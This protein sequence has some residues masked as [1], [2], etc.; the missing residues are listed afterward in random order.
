[1][2]KVP[3]KDVR[4]FVAV[5]T[6]GS[7]FPEGTKLLATGEYRDPLP[8]ELF[9]ANNDEDSWARGDQLNVLIL[10][11]GIA[12]GERYIL[13]G[14]TAEGVA[15]GQKESTAT[16]ETTKTYHVSVQQE[17][18]TSFASRPDVQAT[19]PDEAAESYEGFGKRLI[20]REKG[21]KNL[22]WLYE[23]VDKPRFQKV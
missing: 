20:I 17:D 23:L 13:A 3:P 7:E 8:G 10:K 1:M 6:K 9:V 18:S 12:I 22:Q 4:S 15:E 5:A 11:Q 2:S 19:N 16:T 21:N 14:P